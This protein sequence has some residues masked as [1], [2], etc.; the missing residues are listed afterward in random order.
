MSAFEDLPDVLKTIRSRPLFVMRLVVKPLLQVG[1]TPNGYRRVGIVTGGTFD[2]ERL[3]GIVLDGSSDWQTVRRD[4]ITLDVRL[5][6][7]TNDGELVTMTY[8][9]YRHGPPEVLQKI[10]KGE[11]VDPASYYFRIAP[12]FE[13]AGRHDWL[14]RIIAVGIGHR[15]AEGPTYSVFEIL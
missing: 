11:T 15:T 4:A 10:D 1:A 14:N 5:M 7:Q 6:L 8:R 13:T 12:V 9:G 3:S 2:G